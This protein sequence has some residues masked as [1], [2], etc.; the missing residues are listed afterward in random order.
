MTVQSFLTMIRSVPT[1]IIVP[2]LTTIRSVIVAKE[3]RVVHEIVALDPLTLKIQT[4]TF[5]DKNPSI[6][7]LYSQTL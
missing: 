6:L 7:N 5:D 2:V 3:A 4:H 1:V